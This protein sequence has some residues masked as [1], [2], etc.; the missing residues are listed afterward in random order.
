MLNLYEVD[1]VFKDGSK[2]TG[3]V[4]A[5]NAMDAREQAVELYAYYH[6]D[7]TKALMVGTITRA[8]NYD[9]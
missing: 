4:V 5:E 9:L 6:A 2:H 3:Q 8:I 1:V 7:W